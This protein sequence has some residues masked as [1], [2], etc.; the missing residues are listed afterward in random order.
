MIKF[1]SF[2]QFLLDIARN[3]IL[4]FQNMFQNHLGESLRSS[5]VLNNENSIQ[6]LLATIFPL[7]R[8]YLCS[9]PSDGNTRYQYTELHKSSFAGQFTS[10][11]TFFSKPS[12]FSHLCLTVHVLRVFNI[13]F[14]PKGLPLNF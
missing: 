11:F 4:Y 1:F 7:R 14:A 10:K 6:M 5:L 8:W 2:K 12:S 3:L 9:L 13:F